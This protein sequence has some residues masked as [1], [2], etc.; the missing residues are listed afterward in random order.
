MSNERKRRQEA[1]ELVK[2]L[3]SHMNSFAKDYSDFVEMVVYQ[4][5][6]TL[7]QNTMRLVLQLIQG[8]AKAHDDNRY[9]L[10]NEATCKAAKKI[11]ELFD[12]EIP[13]LPVV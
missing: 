8:W 11:M 7:Q 12:N 13:F 3:S 1:K 2:L 6:R 10:R 4:E 5:H 9:D